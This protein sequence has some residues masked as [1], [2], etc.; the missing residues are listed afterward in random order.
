MEALALYNVAVMRQII[1]ARQRKNAAEMLF[2]ARRNMTPK[3]TQGEVA[4]A[5]G[6]SLSAV[7]RWERDGMIPGGINQQ[8]VLRFYGLRPDALTAAQLDQWDGYLRP[9]LLASGESEQTVRDAER[10][11]ALGQEG[12]PLEGEAALEDG[13]GDP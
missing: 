8:E 4:V 7:G 12:W 9:F 1:T 6:M 5:L 11:E 10:A 2:Q 3:R 13:G